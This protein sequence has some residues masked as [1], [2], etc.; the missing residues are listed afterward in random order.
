MWSQKLWAVA[1]AG[2]AVVNLLPLAG[3]AGASV[4]QRLYGQAIDD[5]DLLLLLRCL[6]RAQRRSARP[7]ADAGGTGGG[8]AARIRQQSLA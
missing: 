6:C 1:L 5:P 7:R 2:A 4:L 3:I 8:T